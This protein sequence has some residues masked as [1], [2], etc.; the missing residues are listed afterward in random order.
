ML[1][2]ERVLEAIIDKRDSK[3]KRL[4]EQ[5]TALEN[6]IFSYRAECSA[7]KI[8]N[9]DLVN[10]KSLLSR[11]NEMQSEE[12]RAQ[13]DQMSKLTQQ[14]DDLKRTVD[15]L[16]E[17]TDNVEN[18]RKKLTE[19]QMKN[20]DL[21]NKLIQANETIAKNAEIIAELESKDEKNRLAL[22]QGSIKY[23]A[24]VMQ[25][26]SDI[27]KLQDETRSLR[28]QLREAEIKLAW[29]ND[30]I[31]T[32]RRESD[33]AMS[34]L[35]AN[36]SDLDTDKERLLTKVDYLKSEIVSY[37]NSTASVESK[38]QELSHGNETLKADIE[39]VKSTNDQLLRTH[40]DTVKSSLKDTLYTLP[41]RIY[42]KI[43]RLQT[44]VRKYDEETDNISERC[45]TK[46]TVKIEDTKEKHKTKVYIDKSCQQ[47]EDKLDS[48]AQEVNYNT[49]T[50][51]DK[52]RFLKRQYEEKLQEMKSLMN[53]VKLRDYE[54]KNLQECIT[55]LSQ[56]KNNLQTKVE[57]QKEEYQNKLK[58]LKKK[59]DS[60]LNA[61]RKRHNENVE[62]LQARFEDIMK[63][64]KSPFNPEDWLQ[65]LN[66]KELSDLH[67]RINILSSHASE[68]IESNTS[69]AEAEKNHCSYRNNSGEHK[70]YNKFTLRKQHSRENRISSLN[71]KASKKEFPSKI[72]NTENNEKV[73]ITE[74][75]SRDVSLAEKHSF[76][77]D[78][79]K[80]T[81]K[82]ELLKAK[83][84][85][86]LDWQR[87]KFIYQC[88][89]H[90][91]LSNAR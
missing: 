55:S 77:E 65:S 66:L 25:K 12:I 50:V 89:I 20:N 3:I 53:D 56:E 51:A 52:L 8:E 85:R 91:K 75:Y 47:D 18:M 68:N 42:E 17:K 48:V 63:I 38:L 49:E 24:M 43:L 62:M 22:T 87:E 64:K 14:I 46:E 72:L 30:T 4:H 19:L 82:A 57:C 88:S 34:I 74:L 6:D 44:E 2:K 13:R 78:G 83:T 81:E 76:P 36:L 70:F 58:L 7:L 23:D 69:R 84:D 1:E 33:N 86:T 54:I 26:R 11:E 10:I 9:A 59:Y 32:L 28:D 35:Q 21:T 39:A 45:P 27:V 29:S 41:K 16:K 71:K 80:Q 31:L 40:E 90:H 61:F 79:R 67:N 15:V 73:I 60:S 5:L 37:R